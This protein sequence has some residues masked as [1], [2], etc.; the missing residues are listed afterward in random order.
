M[1][2]FWGR[3]CYNYGL[4]FRKVTSRS[5]KKEDKGIGGRKQ[6]SQLGDYCPS[7]VKMF[8]VRVVLMAVASCQ[9]TNHNSC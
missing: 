7:S 9:R 3:Y 4:C 2:T 5:V 6:P 8:D 1:R